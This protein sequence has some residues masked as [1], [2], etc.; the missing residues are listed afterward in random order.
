M[1]DYILVGII[2]LSGLLANFNREKRFY[3]AKATLIVGTET[4]LGAV[5]FM[6]LISLFMYTR[7]NRILLSDINSLFSI[8]L[9]IAVINGFILYWINSY[10]LLRFKINSTVQTLCEYIIQWS[11]IYVTVYQVVFDNLVTTLNNFHVQQLSIDKIDITN[12][13]EL[14]LLVLPS[15]ISVWISI[16]MYK[17]KCNKL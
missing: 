4:F 5:L 7:L 6:I 15:L 14:I 17:L 8:I 10:I 1:V 16:I 11:L 9:L 12:P 13:T 2:L 3:I